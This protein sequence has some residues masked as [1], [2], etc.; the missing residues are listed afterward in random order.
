MRIGIIFFTSLL[1]YLSF[2]TIIPLL[3]IIFLN[4]DLLAA[5]P[6]ET[7]YL[8]LGCLYATYP[9]AQIISNPILGAFSDRIG[10][11]TILILSY[12][13]DGL[14]YLL[15]ALGLIE[16]HVILMFLGF[17]IAGLTGCNVA[18]SY[19]YIADASIG[20]RKIRNYIFLNML[21]GL[22]FIVGPLLSMQIIPYY[23]FIGGASITFF[24]AI[25]L[26]LS[27]DKTGIFKQPAGLFQSLRQEKNLSFLA[28]LFFFFFG[29][30][31]FMKFFQ[32]FL[33][34]SKVEMYYTLSYCSL[35]IFLTQFFFSFIVKKTM[36][37]PLLIQAAL[38]ILAFSILSLSF[39]E[40][41]LLIIPLFSAAYAFL[42][43]SLVF[44]M[45]EKSGVSS[46]GKSMGVYQAVQGLGKVLAPLLMGITMQLHWKLPLFLSCLFI[47]TSAL[48]F[49]IKRPL[50]A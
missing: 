24:N 39:T 43:P 4:T 31:F 41:L 42:C 47:L 28:T 40:N 14:G 8:L 29:W 9:L 12:L 37:R 45:S 5:Y 2:A 16:Q 38:L 1:D 27:L 23:A 34:L 21:M 17:F 32:L 22:A 10:R 13:G 15:F 46:Q 49:R 36:D 11:K 30:Y 48:T 50:T 18:A 19:A 20:E 44:V 7:R 26:G 35:C 25:L 3:P 6:E 33:L